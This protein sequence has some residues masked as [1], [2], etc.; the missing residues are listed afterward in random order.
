M[1]AAELGLLEMIGLP[2]GAKERDKLV[3]VFGK[4]GAMLGS[5]DMVGI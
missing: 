2:L 4:I 1:V 3:I 5:L